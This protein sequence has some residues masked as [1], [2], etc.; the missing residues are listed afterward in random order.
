MIASN[1]ADP[2]PPPSRTRQSQAD[3]LSWC[4]KYRA[5]VRADRRQ[6]C[7]YGCNSSSFHGWPCR[8]RTTRASNIA[9]GVQQQSVIE[10]SHAAA[11]KR[12]GL[13]I[14]TSFPIDQD[15]VEASIDGWLIL[16]R[17]EP[18]FVSSRVQPSNHVVRSDFNVTRFTLAY[19]DQNNHWEWLR[20]K[21][22]VQLMVH[23]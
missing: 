15:S 7:R 12:T 4:A 17:I 19:I 3:Q 10:A 13:S 16:V 22:S 9:D 8:P 18:T 2:H 6:I 21:K 20:R 14:I 5:R 23:E 11:R 1:S